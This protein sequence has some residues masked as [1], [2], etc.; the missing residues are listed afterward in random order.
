MLKNKTITVF[1][2]TGKVGS[3][4]V[5]MA[6]EQGYKLKV[7]I[8]NKNKFSHSNNP[9]VK[10]IVGSATNSK[11]VEEA[12]QGSDVVVSLLGNVGDSTIMYEAHNAILDVAKKQETTPRCLMISS[13]GCGGSSWLIKQLLKHKFIGKKGYND[14]EKADKRIRE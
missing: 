11:N 3:H 4:F 2:A 6:L 7:L 5:Q 14:Y 13:I 10:I 12:I 9:N 8:R 1:G